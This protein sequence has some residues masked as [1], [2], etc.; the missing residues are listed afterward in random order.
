M[1]RKLFSAESISFIFVLITATLNFQKLHVKNIM[2]ENVFYPLFH[3]TTLELDTCKAATNMFMAI[4]KISK[5]GIPFWRSSKCE[6]SLSSHHYQEPQFGPIFKV[7]LFWWQ[8]HRGLC[9][10]WWWLPHW[11]SFLPGL[12][13]ARNAVDLDRGNWMPNMP[14][15]EQTKMDTWSFQGFQ[16]WINVPGEHKINDPFY[17]RVPTKDLCPWWT[18]KEQ[19]PRP[20]SWRERPWKS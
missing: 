7:Q 17:G 9:P 8:G 15:G 10:A 3:E 4:K 20:V 18:W 11:L 13:H 16:I 12:W 1:W 5:Q 6:T 2:R 19:E 14:K